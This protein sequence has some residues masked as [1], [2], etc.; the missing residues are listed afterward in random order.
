M[1][2]K[3]K[4]SDESKP[5]LDDLI[6]LEEAAELSGFSTGHLR[7]LARKGDLWATKIT[8]HWVTTRVAIETYLTRERR[9]G[10]KTKKGS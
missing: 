8:G 5:G 6:S 9:P 7:H 10:P 3:N 1:S 2:G 4:T